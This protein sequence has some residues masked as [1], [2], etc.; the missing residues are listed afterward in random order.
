M[1][2]AGRLVKLPLPDRQTMV[3]LVLQHPVPAAECEI[4]TT[5]TPMS[6]CEISGGS[7]HPCPPANT[8]TVQ[9]T[10]GEQRMADGGAPLLIALLIALIPTRPT[11]QAIR[12]LFGLKAFSRW[13]GTGLKQDEPKR[14][15]RKQ[16]LLLW[17]PG[18]NLSN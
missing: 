10:G 8:F 17:K 9:V 14:D 7:G 13:T 1:T 4:F 15:E 5:P 18:P 6:E 16:V 11:G 12:T 3:G 2:A